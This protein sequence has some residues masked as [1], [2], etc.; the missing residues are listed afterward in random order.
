M[1]TRVLQNGG[2]FFTNYKMAISQKRLTSVD[3][4]KPD[5]SA[6]LITEP[7]TDGIISRHNAISTSQGGS[8]H[9]TLHHTPI[10]STCPTYCSLFN[11]TVPVTRR[12]HDHSYSIFLVA[13]GENGQPREEKEQSTGANVRVRQPN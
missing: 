3:L 13:V 8:P 12:G 4:A 7:S 5:C 9:R 2:K 6:A 11:F 1:K 10:L